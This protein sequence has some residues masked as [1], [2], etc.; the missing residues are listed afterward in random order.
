[1]ASSGILHRVALVRT[2]VSEELRA[3]FIRVTRLGELGT[4][5][6]VTINRRRPLTP[7]HACMYTRGGPGFARSLH[8]DLKHLS[9]PMSPICILVL[10]THL[11]LGLS[12]G[13]F[14]SGFPTNYQDAFLFPHSCYM[15]RPSHPPGLHH[16]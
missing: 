15:P 16:S 9:H 3:S 13:L 12:S 10:S 11:H 1:M 6:A 2:D 4:S 14:V 7:P 8:C 5:L